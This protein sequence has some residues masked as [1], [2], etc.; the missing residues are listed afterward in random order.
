MVYAIA[1]VALLMLADRW[2]EARKR[3]A[4]LGVALAAM[5]IFTGLLY[6]PVVARSGV[7]AISANPFVTPMSLGAVPGELA[8]RFSEIS[9]MWRGDGSGLFVA[10]LCVGTALSLYTVEKRAGDRM[11]LLALAGIA[12]V[13]A[14]GFLQRRVAPVRV[15]LYLQAWMIACA[16]GAA[17]QLVA[18]KQGAQIAMAAGLILLAGYDGYKVKK[19]PLLIS[20][21]PHTFVEAGEVAAHLV[22]AGAFRGD[23]AVI[24]NSSENL[25]PPLLYYLIQMQPDVG[26]LADWNGP[27][28]R[29][30]FVLIARTDRI[31]DFLRSRPDFLSLYETPQA[32]EVTRNSCLYLAEHR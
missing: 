13:L 14:A 20:E 25:W 11:Q 12:V 15:C 1:P 6:A 30:I 5:G 16:C 10:F 19:Q 7:A 28:S 24:W 22:Q 18:R 4:P 8:S 3:V 23:T 32:V 26:Q 17:A 29:R 21:D 27:E 9:M 31:E 2:D